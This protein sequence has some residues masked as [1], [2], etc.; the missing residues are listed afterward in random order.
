MAAEAIGAV[1]V[2]EPTAD[3]LLATHFQQIDRNCVDGR[4]FE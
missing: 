2:R 3:T 1:K 4:S